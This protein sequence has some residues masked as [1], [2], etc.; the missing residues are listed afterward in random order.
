MPG[1]VTPSADTTMAVY[2]MSFPGSP[3][4]SAASPTTKSGFRGA[5][6]PGRRSNAK[7]Q[8]TLRSFLESPEPERFSDRGTSSE[9]DSSSLF[10]AST[11]TSNTLTS[12]DDASLR[13][14]SLRSGTS[15][16]SSNDLLPARHST[17]CCTDLALRRELRKKFHI[18]PAVDEP[19]PRNSFAMG[20]SFRR[21][22]EVEDRVESL[23]LWEETEMTTSSRDRVVRKD[24]NNA[25]GDS[26]LSM[27]SGRKGLEPLFRKP[28][29]SGSFFNGFFSG[30]SFSTSR[31]LRKM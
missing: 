16:T 12:D 21:E 31:R 17:A 15:T 8:P 24:V 1:K 20:H 27:G 23:A 10:T 3:H 30:L 2:K 11:R 26:A 28:K 6:F 9:D 13:E 14:L 25:F 22:L 5:M 4:K 18:E 29:K 19:A 7:V